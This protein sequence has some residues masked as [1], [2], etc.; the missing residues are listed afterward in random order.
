[1]FCEPCGRER[2]VA[3]YCVV[4]GSAL[5][6]RPKPQ[7]EADLEKVR[8]LL[9]EV[10]TWDESVAAAAARRSIREFYLRQEATLE[11]AFA[12]E[13]P[14]VEAE[15]D[16]VGVSAPD[17]EE[18]SVVSLPE[19]VP[20]PSPPMKWV[21]PVEAP[22]PSPPRPPAPPPKPAGPSVW[23]RAWKPFL[24][25]S[26]GWFIG[27]FLIL[28]GALYLV[29][30]AWDGMTSTT[31]ALTVFGFT[32][33]W[34]AGFAAWSMTLSRKETTKA[35]SRSLLRIA[36]LVS[37]LS[38]LALGPSLS[39]PFTWLALVLGVGISAYLTW[40]AAPT[41]RL[42]LM[43]SVALTTLG[44]GV[45]PVLPAW[46]GW[47]VVVPALVAAVAFRRQEGDR[48]GAALATFAVPVL[49]LGARFLFAW[50]DH[51]A[52]FAGACVAAAVLGAGARWLRKSHG[53]ITVLS[54]TL[55]IAAFIASFFA[56]KPACVV[57]ALLGAWSTWTLFKE[58]TTP[59]QQWWLS[60]TY[61]FSY[62]AWQRLDQLVPPIVWVWWSALKLQLGYDA[63]PM[64]AS[65]GSVFQALFIAVSTLAAAW[66]LRR[67]PK[68]HAAHVWLRSSV[69]AAIA[70]GVL[71]MVGIGGD[72]RPAMVALPLLLVPMWLAAVFAN[73]RDAQVAGGVLTVLFAY[74][75][76]LAVNAAWIAGVLAVLA[77]AVAWL[78]RPTRANRSLR[79][80][81]SW[82]AL[83]SATV[84]LIG[85]VAQHDVIALVLGAGAA[86][87]VTRQ[88]P[89]RLGDGEHVTPSKLL[90][91][92]VAF[93]MLI[94]LQRIGSPLV[95]VTVALAGAASLHW[96]RRWSAVLPAL[97]TT[98]GLALVSVVLNRAAAVDVRMLAVVVAATGVLF[99][100]AG[101]PVAL[102]VAAVGLEFVPSYP[103]MLAPGFT[104]LVAAGALWLL[105][106][107]VRLGAVLEAPALLAAVMAFSPT[108]VFGGFWSE[109]PNE[110][111]VIAMGAFALGASVFASMKGRSWR[112]W[113]VATLA[114]LA[115][116]STVLTGKWAL[117]GAA[118]VVSLA[119]PALFAWLTVPLAAGLFALF[120]GDSQGG[121][122]A[123][124]AGVSLVA[125][126]EESDFT[127]TRLLNRTPVAWL[128]SLSAFA[129][130]IGARAVAEPGVWLQ[131]AVLAL[132][133]VWARATR[134]SVAMVVA[135]PLVAACF[136]WW[137]APLYA[138]L[139]ARVPMLDVVRDLTG[140]RARGVLESL[141]I[142]FIV[143]CTA[144]VGLANRESPVPWA[145][146]LMLGGGPFFA[147]RTVFASMLFAGARE[148]WP[149]V[150]GALTAIAALV[151]HAPRELCR[152]FAT[153]QL[154]FA[155]VTS[156]MTA[157]VGAALLVAFPVS[158]G[159]LPWWPCAGI[160]AALTA[161]SFLAPA[162]LRRAFTVGAC[163]SLSLLAMVLPAA[164]L[165]P[166]VLVF[167]AV[168]LGAPYLL[169]AAV[170][171][172]ALSWDGSMLQL[173]H[174][175]PVVL[176][177]ALLAI[178]LRFEQVREVVERA[179]RRLGRGVDL[180][181]AP[182]L[183][184]GAMLVTAMMV[185]SGDTHALWV[186][187]LLLLTPS[188]TEFI[189]GL[190]VTC[191][192][193]VALAPG[194]VAVCALCGLSLV[195]AALGSFVQ[196]PGA[197]VWRHAGW[198]TALL[199]VAL[200]GVDLHSFLIP[201]AWTT[202]ATAVWFAV[203]GKARAHGAA[204]ATTA[205]S[206]HVVFGFVGTVL[207]H[208]DPQVLIAPWWALGS[209]TLALIRHLRG[210]RVSVFTFGAL[211]I[212][213]L[214]VPGFVLQ[215]PY[216]RES[217]ACLAAS[218]VLVFI[219]A[220]RV[221]RLDEGAAAWL[222]QFALIAGAFS[223]RVLLAGSMPGLT[224][225][226]ALLAVAAVVSGLAQLL[227]REGRVK[228]AAAL[229]VGATLAP[230]LGAVF[231]PWSQWTVSAA[232]LLGVSAV[233][234]LA[235]RTGLK[236]HGSLMSAAAFNAAMVIGAL[237]AGFGSMQL[238]LVPAGVTV[239]A[240]V[241]VFRDELAPE[242]AVKLRALGMASLYAAVAWEPLFVTSLPALA[243]CVL[244]CLAGIALGM[245]WRVRSYVLLG[246]GALV[247]TVISTLVR[248]G[249]AEPRLGA[250][251]LS[252]LG[253]VVVV[254]MVVLSTKREELKARL[255]S[256]QRTMATWSP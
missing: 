241:R 90:M 176:G 5:V 236:R 219:A 188:R 37:P 61:A 132:P 11:A 71:A 159:S 193:F 75:S 74:A 102:G 53:A 80:A 166:A 6:A 215:S 231:V 85:G 81:L 89:L 211:A 206:L 148:Q 232:W 242:V 96:H 39:S 109:W 140:L 118:V 205:V 194:S 226:W 3:R 210:G 143:L 208:G 135:V 87:A 149:A 212:A 25:E 60:G 38:V 54:M 122:V 86:I 14:A 222:G 95:S 151:R 198:A 119:T 22:P 56:L 34:G 33:A 65:Y 220:R 100:R 83:G 26:L 248:S 131:C 107:R 98:I 167:A 238:L 252:A 142:H 73:R 144:L 77:G 192:A 29:A 184:A 180:P 179:W 52:L 138:L 191:W 209:A 243:L 57:I 214:L 129:V 123:L 178:A 223:A 249:L 44:L 12:W 145:L 40:R 204:W 250:I 24:H 8:W 84:A 59:R 181:V 218:G 141:A 113:L 246:T 7:I 162:R 58:A 175:T 51:A 17:R 217:L 196:H 164:T 62:L 72:V 106:R 94:P 47:L 110:L 183:S 152:A 254:V 116:L 88:L 189:A 36:S 213:E 185:F 147:A 127:W 200:A 146:V 234:G 1:M 97:V 229:R 49:V 105:S 27:A 120:I 35:A 216:V 136:P 20:P 245:H 111:S 117:L 165:L 171:S 93:V 31:R 63:K 201:L 19:V 43:I 160:T 128:A 55:L 16:P 103:V 221:V 230:V 186:A 121:L 170:F 168:L 68:H 153:R 130:L 244:V 76:T 64:P 21:R 157:I 126:F 42:E 177:A 10:T 9:D 101:W 66:A 2:N 92:L 173:A 195:V 82:T 172:A 23:Q 187:P 182:W 70:S 156:V 28:S 139:S 32:Q 174:G 224:D 99:T 13:P 237:G 124:A 150:V 163:L 115:A 199:A 112:T 67:D 203:R 255:A 50:P 233:G 155:E 125:L 4:C 78:Q 161:A 30:D 207:S 18:V 133:L 169:T 46:C 158:V 228:S 134:T 15:V 202:L 114:V 190:L 256:V 69:V 104:W 253:L 227:A 79:R 225:A 41:S 91:A 239:L 154:A 48:A 247:T 45:A 197:P 240:L 251:F 235:A 108:K 137:V